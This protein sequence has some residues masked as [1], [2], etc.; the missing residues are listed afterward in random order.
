MAKTAKT[1]TMISK[2]SPTSVTNIDVAVYR[3]S[4][5]VWLIKTYYMVRYRGTDI[6]CVWNRI[7]NLN[8][9]EKRSCKWFFVE[10]MNILL[11]DEMTFVVLHIFHSSAVD[12]IVTNMNMSVWIDS[13]VFWQHCF[14]NQTSEIFGYETFGIDN[15]KSGRLFSILKVDQF[16]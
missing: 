7:L 1:V 15:F 3:I 6:S 14:S 11:W 9:F 4:Y 5:T 2:L 16:D 12:D 13:I 8:E 10:K